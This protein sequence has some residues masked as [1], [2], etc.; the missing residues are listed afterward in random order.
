MSVGFS[1]ASL[2]RDV[3]AETVVDVARALDVRVV[4]FD[5]PPRG[6][7]A[8]R[9]ALKAHAIEVAAI[10]A[11]PGAPAA[12][13]PAASTLRAGCLRVDAGVR[14]GDREAHVDR[15]V[16]ALHP[17]VTA[18]IPV[19]LRFARDAEDLLDPE[20]LDWA[21]SELPALRVW[22]DAWRAMQLAGLER[23]PSPERLADDLASRCVGVS[24]AGPGREGRGGGHP[25]DG[26][27]D[28]S[29]LVGA[30]PRDAA[31][32]VELDPGLGRGALED[33]VRVTRS[34]FVR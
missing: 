32:V 13:L 14:D 22:F 26:G 5:G 12:S 16:R 15:L 3:G 18:G 10:D 31:W 28:W 34:W 7:Q 27:P 33:A 25:E 29:T 20:A 23:G 21:L 8:W 19:A 30:L 6:A 4:S 1:V 9:A 17:V 2:G 11:S 24:V